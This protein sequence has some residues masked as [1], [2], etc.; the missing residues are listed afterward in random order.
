[1]RNLELLRSFPLLELDGTEE[2]FCLTVDC[3]C[4]T[5]YTATAAGITGF[6]PSSQEVSCI[7]TP[8]MQ[9]ASETCAVRLKLKEKKIHT[10]ES[11]GTNG[12]SWY[13]SDQK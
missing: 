2:P 5:V 6:Q 8:V 9:I 11:W 12:P 4:G 7:C 10:D 1:M 3:D 13:A